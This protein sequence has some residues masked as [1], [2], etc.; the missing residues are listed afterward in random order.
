MP[1]IHEVLGPTQL[2][3]I[4]PWRC[5]TIVPTIHEVLGPTQSQKTKPWRCYAIVRAIHNLL[6]P[7]QPQKTEYTRKFPNI[8]LQRISSER[9]YSLIKWITNSSEFNLRSKLGDLRRN[10]RWQQP[11]PSREVSETKALVLGLLDHLV[12]MLSDTWLQL[13]SV[14]NETNR[15]WPKTASAGMA[16]AKSEVSKNWSVV[17]GALAKVSKVFRN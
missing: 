16:K 7:T 3:K 11:K 14:S 9:G 4:K 10:K 5:C 17:L 1:A 13:A 12:G 15:K 8:T 2:Q 6:R